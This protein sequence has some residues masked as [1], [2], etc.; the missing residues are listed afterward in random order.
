MRGMSCQ[1]HEGSECGMH[2]TRSTGAVYR[3]SSTELLC[4]KLS[5]RND[6]ALIDYTPC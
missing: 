1:R 5:V 3:E 4:N 6:I 2:K